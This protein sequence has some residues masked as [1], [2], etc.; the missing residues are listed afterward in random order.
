MFRYRLRILLLLTPLV[1]LVAAFLA[2]TC[3]PEPF[4][5]AAGAS[6]AMVAVL[7]ISWPLMTGKGC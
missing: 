4:D 6:L 1:A 2:G 5:R 7:I 3:L